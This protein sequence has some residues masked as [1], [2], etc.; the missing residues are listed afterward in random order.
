MTSLDACI[1]TRGKMYDT[2]VSECSAGSLVGN[3]GDL[4]KYF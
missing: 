4:F 1:N 2:S 3:N